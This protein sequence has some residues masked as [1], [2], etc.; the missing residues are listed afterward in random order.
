MPVNFLFDS[1]SIYLQA[2]KA[3]AKLTASAPCVF[4]PLCRACGGTWHFLR[5]AG[6]IF[7]WLRTLSPASPEDIFLI[8]SVLLATDL[9]PLITVGLK[10][11][12]RKQIVVL[13]LQHLTVSAHDVNECLLKW[14]ENHWNWAL[15]SAAN[16]LRLEKVWEENHFNVFLKWHSEQHVFSQECRYIVFIA[17]SVFSWSSVSVLRK[18][19]NH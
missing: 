6:T 5:R 4:L 7:P 14:M 8:P 13:C 12:L 11:A 19:W 9:W 3:P 1:L 2:S 17:Y 16:I 18:H 15:A 10:L